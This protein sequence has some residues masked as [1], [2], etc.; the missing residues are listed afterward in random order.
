[1]VLAHP[2]CKVEVERRVVEH[3]R[4]WK[5][6]IMAFALQYLNDNAR[7]DVRSA[8]HQRTDVSVLLLRSW[9]GQVALTLSLRSR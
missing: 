4:K 7:Q 3:Q 9:E 1:M 5:L 6:E 2:R 8:L